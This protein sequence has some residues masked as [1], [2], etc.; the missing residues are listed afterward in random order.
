LRRH[1]LITSRA[2]GP[3]AVFKKYGFT[4]WPMSRATARHVW[5]NDSYRQSHDALSSGCFWP[6]AVMV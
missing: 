5:L 2:L 4:L 6:E 3:E 1:S